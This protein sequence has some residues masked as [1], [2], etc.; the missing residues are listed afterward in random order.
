[1]GAL[2]SGAKN[3]TLAGTAER[4]SSVS[5]PARWVDIQAKFGNTDSVFIG[6]STVDSASGITLSPGATITVGNLQRWFT[7]DLHGIWIDSAVNG[8]GVTFN[9]WSFP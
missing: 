4:L 2:V 3:I 6:D 7:L 5:V 9:Y 8:E 1:M